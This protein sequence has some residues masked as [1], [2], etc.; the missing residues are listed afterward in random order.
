MVSFLLLIIY[1]SLSSLRLN[2]FIPALSAIPFMKVAA[3]LLVAA[4]LLERGRIRLFLDIPQNK[5]IVAI[6]LI[7]FLSVPFAFHRSVC[8]YGVLG[9]CKG[10]LVYL[11]FL[12]LV[13]SVNN[14]KTLLWVSFLSTCYIPFTVM[15]I[16]FTGGFEGRWAIEGSGAYGDANDLAAILV[17]AAPLIL[18]LLQLN[19]SFLVKSALAGGLAA[20]LIGIIFT[21]SRGGFIGLVAVCVYYL[22]KSKKKIVTLIACGVIAILLFNFLPGGSFERFKTISFFHQKEGDT[23]D[24]RI[25]LWKE[26]LRMA[27]D[28]PIF[29]V[30]VNCFGKA[31]GETYHLNIEKLENK[32]LAPHNSFIT[33][34]SESGVIAFLCCIGVYYFTFKDLRDIKRRLKDSEI[35]TYAKKEVSILANAFEISLVGFIVCAFFLGHGLPLFHFAFIIVIKRITERLT[36]NNQAQ[37]GVAA[38]TFYTKGIKAIVR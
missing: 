19:K 9:F 1:A 17:T 3:G 27:M 5:L 30:G 15:K 32:W 37:I 35:D 6:T 20:Y 11:I 16:H 31:L 36:F 2:E 13:K 26:G 29:G 18:A 24:I 7:M 28:Y 10:I 22:M 4:V 21:Q 8:F 33:I 14:I 23:G 12:D 25:E 38:S 34:L